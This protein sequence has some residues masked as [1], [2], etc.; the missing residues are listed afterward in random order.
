L[1]VLGMG[2]ISERLSE[3]VSEAVYSFFADLMEQAVQWI[4][5][6]IVGIMSTAENVLNYPIVIQGILYSQGIAIIML[7]I[8][9]AFEAFQT[10]IL[11]NS[12][13]SNADPKGLLIGTVKAAAVIGTM[14]WLV[15]YLYLVGTA[16]AIDVS[17]LSGVQT[18]KA[19]EHFI[20]NA[21]VGGFFFVIICL[22]SLVLII[23][24]FIQ[25][26][27]RAA[28][29]GLLAVIGPVI[30]VQEVG[31]NSQLFSLWLKELVVVCFSQAIQIFLIL[32]AMYTL[33]NTGIED[34]IVSSAM[35]LGWLWVTVKAP[36]TIKQMMYS[37]GV[38]SAAAGAAQTAGTMLIVRKMMTKGV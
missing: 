37:S 21:A 35:L 32:A 5:G 6:A 7:S 2:W 4:A 29:L 22:I 12:G 28:A 3:M 10:W 16:M 30:A 18:E 11:Y 20:L 14:P 23:A 36:S 33:S 31:G 15:R 17:R 24:V 25:T 38:G 34:I 19:L 9:V 27:I 13:D 8:K 26:F 1:E